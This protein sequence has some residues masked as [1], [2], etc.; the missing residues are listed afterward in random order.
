MMKKWEGRVSPLTMGLSV[1]DGQMW[2]AFLLA[3]GVPSTFIAVPLDS[4]V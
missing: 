4:G 2:I 1:L 3:R